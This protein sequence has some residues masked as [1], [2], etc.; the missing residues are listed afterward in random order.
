VRSEVVR[1]LDDVVGSRDEAHLRVGD[2]AAALGVSA[3]TLYRIFARHRGAPPI[4]YLRVLRLERVRDRLLAG[5]PGE[6]VTST[7][8]DFG[9]NHLGRFA[10]GY[11]RCFGERPSQT[12]RR[13]RA[14]AAVA[15]PELRLAPHRS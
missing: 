11:R 14:R 5:T 9:F 15:P 13:A 4:S 8:L 10:D 12:L 7:A 2:L 1:R 6:T 3:R